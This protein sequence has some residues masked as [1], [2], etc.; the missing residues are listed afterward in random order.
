MRRLLIAPAA[1]VAA[2]ALVIGSAPTIASAATLTGSNTIPAQVDG[3]EQTRT[4]PI[5]GDGAVD[6]V[7]ITVDFSKTDGSCAAPASGNAFHQ[8]I[9][10]ALVSPGGT[11]VDLVSYGSYTYESGVSGR[12]ASITFDDDAATQVGGTEPVSGTF[13]PAQSLSAFD[14][15]PAAGDW[16]VILGDGFPADPLCFTQAALTVVTGV[17]TLADATL[18]SGIVG[19]AYS[20]VIAATD[21]DQPITYALAEGSSAPAGLTLAADGTLSGTPSVSGDLALDVVAS[22]ADGDSAPATFTVRI[23]Q[24][25]AIDGAATA[26]AQ[27][28]VPFSY[29]PELEP[30]DP[31]AT[32]TATGLPEGLEVD[33]A[34]GEISGTPTGA[35]GTF[36]VVLTADNGVEPADTLQLQLAVVAGPA[37]SIALTPETLA[38]GTGSSQAFVVSG[39]DAEGNAADV[40]AATLTSSDASDVVDGLTV[41]F[42]T[43]GSRT[44]TAT[45]GE[46]ADAA[47]VEVAAA[48]V[49]SAPAPSAPAPS[50]PP[51][52]GPS[53]PQTGGA[54][55]GWLALVAGLLVAGGVVVRRRS[56]A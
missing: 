14:G 34:T 6:D 8:E 5:V 52:A 42:G 16:T 47:I 40:S 22:N 50:A 15:Q 3:G 35:L 23:D 2:A 27:I 25:A 13:R 46:L 24:R 56:R 29:L 17:P 55:A 26:A 49:P 37:V 38:I 54:I 10:L 36:A 4:I 48:P 44:I 30:G 11:T 21:G 45:L 9:R 18:P 12:S 19:D 41:T 53:L 31:A 28:A 39:V 43:P 32:V 20:T 1:L 33:A 51:V 7:T